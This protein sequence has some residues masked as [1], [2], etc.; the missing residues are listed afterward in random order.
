MISV[1][2]C[3]YNR[4][5]MLRAAL[6]SLSAMTVPPDVQWELIVVDNNSQDETADA[7]AQFSTTSPVEVRYVFEAQQ[8]LSHARNRGIREAHGDVIAFTDDDVVVDKLWLFHISKT[9]QNFKCMAVAGKVV[10]AWSGSK[11]HWF[12]EERP[13]PLGFAIVHFDLGGTAR[14]I[15]QSGFGANM[16]FRKEAFAKYG[17]FRTDLGRFKDVLMVGEETEF[18]GRLINGREVMAYTPDAVVHH[19]VEEA[20]VRKAYFQSWY[21]NFGRSQVRVDGIPK[22]AVCYF[23]VPRYFFRMLARKFVAWVCNIDP[24]RRFHNK[25]QLYCLAGMIAE[26]RRLRTAVS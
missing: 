16:A 10:P 20:R 21:F 8:G 3:T 2:V 4:S 14:R 5:K 1:V 6:Q 23:G 19:P 12:Y 17:L 13:Y 25:I 9:F 18:F 7:V 11:P 22:N 26:C 15:T 24:K